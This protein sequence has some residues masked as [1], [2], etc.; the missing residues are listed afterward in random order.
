MSLEESLVAHC[1]PTLA[2]L[3][4]ANLFPFTP[5]DTARFMTQLKEWRSW[6]ASCG[7]KLMALRRRDRAWLLYL[8]RPDRLVLDVTN[9]GVSDF[10]RRMGYDT[11]DSFDGLLRQLA[12]RLRSRSGFPHEIGVFLGYPLED[13]VGFME[14]KGKNYTCSGCW[15]SYGNPEEAACRFSR[16]HACTADY[17]R[18]FAGGEGVKQLTTAC[19]T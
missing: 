18:R 7:L 3:R 17:L 11:A 14:N 13:V 4:A 1:S 19:V 8:C 16:Y 15:K 5:E 2:G 9:P 10:L 12:A 6:F